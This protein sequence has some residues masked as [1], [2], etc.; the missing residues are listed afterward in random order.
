MLQ[1]P[2]L[3]EVKY[4]ERNHERPGKADDFVRRFRMLANTALNIRLMCT[5]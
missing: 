4:V 5:K 1:S 3:D 2:E